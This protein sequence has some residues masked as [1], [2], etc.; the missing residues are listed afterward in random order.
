MMTGYIT[1]D[2]GIYGKF[3]NV[4]SE[5]ISKNFIDKDIKNFINELEEKE[6]FIDNIFISKK[7]K[8]TVKFNNDDI[9]LII[10]LFIYHY[11]NNLSIPIIFIESNEDFKEE[12]I[13]LGKIKN[14]DKEIYFETDLLKK[15]NLN[16]LI[17]NILNL[18]YDININFNMIK[19]IN[20]VNNN[21]LEKN[22]IIG[23]SYLLLIS[24][25]YIIKDLNNEI[26]NLNQ[27]IL[28][29]EMP[30][31]EESNR[32]VEILNIINK[33]LNLINKKLKI[34][35]TLNHKIELIKIAYPELTKVI[36]ENEFHK[37]KERLNHLIETKNAF[38]TEY[39]LIL[40]HLILRLNYDMKELNK[41]EKELNQDMYEIQKVSNSTFLSIEIL[42]LIASILSISFFSFEIM[43]I[44]NIGS[45]FQSYNVI[46]YL[47]PFSAIILIFFILYRL[48]LNSRGLEH[49]FIKYIFYPNDPYLIIKKLMFITKKYNDEK[50]NIEKLK[51]EMIKIF[52]NQQIDSNKILNQIINLEDKINNKY[53]KNKNKLIEKL[54]KTR[55][56]VK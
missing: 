49:S 44:F 13:E 37:I 3:N 46:F 48:L 11:L 38:E 20:I 41:N 21:E 36:K 51:T 33:K 40:D 27:Y 53:E 1:F 39:S 56:V 29:N 17:L 42:I 10:T 12:L 19:K 14:I 55:W 34:L 23:L 52:K 7:L 28:E 35:K 30:N 16:F 8:I 18:F 6:I 43:K 9:L 2:E 50:N 22:Y 24:I 45:I 25:K 5:L 32:Y 54:N 47:I 15:N 31:F 4:K 26:N